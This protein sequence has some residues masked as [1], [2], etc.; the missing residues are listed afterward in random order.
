MRGAD[1][2]CSARPQASNPRTYLHS[3]PKGMRNVFP[4]IKAVDADAHCG[5]HETPPSPSSESVLRPTHCSRLRGGD[6]SLHLQGSCC[7]NFF[8]SITGFKHQ[9]ILL[10]L[11]HSSCTVPTNT[12]S[13]S[14][15]CCLLVI[16]L[17]QKLRKCARQMLPY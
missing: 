11:R 4:D 2:T 7:F 1:A 14:S 9:L 12:E 3:V 6:L 8:Q 10:Q 17:Q 15:C 5:Q 13:N 16:L